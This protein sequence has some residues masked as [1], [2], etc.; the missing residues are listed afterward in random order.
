MPSMTRIVRT[1]VILVPLLLRADHGTPLQAAPAAT[2]SDGSNI[3]QDSHLAEGEGVEQ[4]FG[5]S[6][7]DAIMNDPTNVVLPIFDCK[8]EGF[9]FRPSEYRADSVVRVS[10]SGKI[11]AT[12]PQ[13]GTFHPGFIFY[14]SGGCE[15]IGM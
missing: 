8:H 10:D 2:A 14:D 7:I 6:R 5:L 4:T 3:R 9:Q 15:I 11:I 13:D 1:L 12:V